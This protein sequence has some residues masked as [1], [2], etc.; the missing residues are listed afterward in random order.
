[1][2]DKRSRVVLFKTDCLYH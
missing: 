2:K 1:M